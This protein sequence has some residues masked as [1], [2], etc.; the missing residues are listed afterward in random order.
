[1][2][3]FDMLWK[4][5]CV[6]FLFVFLGVFIPASL[7]ADHQIQVYRKVPDFNFTER[8]GK[9]MK[10]SDL[11]GNIWIANFIFTRCQSACPLLAGQMARFQE[12]LVGPKIKFVSFS[13]DPEYDTPDVLS[14]YAARYGAVEN[15][16]FF[17][18]GA[19]SAMR[20]FV[21]QGFLLGIADATPEDLA[22]GAEL[23]MHSNRFVLVDQDG[24]I[25]GYYDSSEPS[26]M[27]EL[28]KH[29]LYLSGG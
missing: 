24:Y 10:L 9:E 8:S 14:K 25:R 29:T 1:M 19:K 6:N 27:E 22:S 7:C 26:K 4:Q 13:V 20:D 21:T 28:V 16:W 12:R 5:F 18:T 15:R 3:R 23:V 17:L 11:K 2:L